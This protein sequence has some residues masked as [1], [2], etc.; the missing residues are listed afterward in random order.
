MGDPDPGTLGEEVKVGVRQVGRAE[1]DV[2]R[3]TH[4]CTG[5]LSVKG[6]QMFA[7]LF[8]LLLVDSTKRAESGRKRGGVRT[9]QL[10]SEVQRANSHSIN[11]HTRTHA[12]TD[13]HSK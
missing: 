13:T 7:L 8:V 11:T 1:G 12:Q 2:R 10:P 4:A 3:G 5:A 6:E 9:L